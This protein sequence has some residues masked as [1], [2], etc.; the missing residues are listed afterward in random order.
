VARPLPEASIYGARVGPDLACN[1]SVSDP[2]G[3]FA[4]FRDEGAVQ[5]SDAQRGWVVIGHAA[6][7]AA[8]RDATTLSADRIGTLERVAAQQ[9]E[10]F[11]AVVDLLR[12]WMIFRDPPA[13]TR[14]REPVRAAFTPRRIAEL[15]R[16]ITALVDEVLDTLAARAEPVDL[17]VEFARPIPALVIAALL[18]VEAGERHRFQAWSDELAAIV[19]STNAGS[20]ATSST[21]RAA[22]EFTRFFGRLVARE[23][24]APTGGILTAIAEVDDSDLGD[25][26]LVGLCTLLLFAGHETTTTLLGNASAILC[27]SPEVCEQL[28]GDPTL[29]PSAVEELMRVQGPARTMVRK[30]AVDH[31]REGLKLRARDNVFLSI[32]AANHDPAVFAQPSVMDLARDP[33][34]H[35]G[36]GWGLHHCLGASL[37]RVEARIALARLV[38]RFGPLE[39]VTPVPPLAGY[40]MGFGRRALLV[41]LR[42]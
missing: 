28:R 17:S 41:N 35:L 24:E 29:W 14:L 31:E 10:G 9:P 20:M 5:W 21:V 32:A 7:T 38:E 13:H 3:Y 12:G 4:S 30:V 25:A 1:E 23:R 40:L 6:V 8:F 18:G 33:N 34:P 22:E 39:P 15:E 27:A 42:A 19:F 16:V 26:E 2:A 11:G 37:A 36:F